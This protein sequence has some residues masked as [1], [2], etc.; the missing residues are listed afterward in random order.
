MIC[1]RVF[2]ET[3]YTCSHRTAMQVQLATLCM[4]STNLEFVDLLYA[5]KIKQDKK[6]NLLVIENRRDWKL[7][8][9]VS[10][11]VRQSKFSC[12]LDNRH[13]IGECRFGSLVFLVGFLYAGE[14]HL[15]LSFVLFIHK[16]S[17]LFNR[18]F[19]A[20]QFSKD[21][22]ESTHLML[23]PWRQ[24]SFDDLCDQRHSLLYSSVA[25]MNEVNR[26]SI[27]NELSI[28]S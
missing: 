27:S 13:F 17:V 14:F 12:S 21:K 19:C 1:S 28:K 23:T 24:N 20:N 16:W 10:S 26:T 18:L 2:R 4:S 9:N 3:H 7:L 6:N 8:T 11:E 5:N 22:W 15:K 25:L